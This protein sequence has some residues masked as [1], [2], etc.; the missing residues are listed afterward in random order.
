[1]HQLHAQMLSFPYIPDRSNAEQLIWL[2]GSM[3]TMQHPSTASVQKTRSFDTLSS[4]G[5]I[6]L[7]MHAWVAD[8]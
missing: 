4:K 7:G 1:M 3:R 2:L 5:G 6:I 8:T